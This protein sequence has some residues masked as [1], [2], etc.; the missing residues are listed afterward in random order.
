MRYG[1]I[2]FN[3]DSRLGEIDDLISDIGIILTQQRLN[4][5]ISIEEYSNRVMLGLEDIPASDWQ[6]MSPSEEKA[7]YDEAMETRESYLRSYEDLEIE[8]N[9]MLK[10]LLKKTDLTSFLPTFEKFLTER[11]KYYEAE[12]VTARKKDDGQ[13]AENAYGQ[14]LSSIEAKK[15]AAV[16][17]QKDKAE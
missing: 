9:N 13:A 10:A 7:I 12:M 1:E 8:K 6:D 11:K 5:I 16:F 2:L 17:K 15:V 4:S 14:V 3:K